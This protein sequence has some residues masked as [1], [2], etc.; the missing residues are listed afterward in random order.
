MDGPGHV[1]MYIGH[2]QMI[3]APH[4]G[5]VVRITSVSGT[6]A[7]LGFLGAV[8]PYGNQL[9]GALTTLS[10]VAS[11]PASVFSRMQ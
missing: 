9:L 10:A 1:G 4:T 6:A 7:Q 3:E 5:A 8:R 11:R 2:D